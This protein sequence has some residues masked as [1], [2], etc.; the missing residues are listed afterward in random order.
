MLGHSFND[1]I[2]AL[3]PLYGRDREFAAGAMD[4]SGVRRAIGGS[5]G[6]ERR[7]FNGDTG[8]LRARSGPPSPQKVINGGDAYDVEF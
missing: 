8:A 2:D 3:F 1:S 5:A 4:R 7:G 6:D